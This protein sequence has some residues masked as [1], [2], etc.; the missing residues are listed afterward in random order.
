MED[1]E[2]F[3]QLDLLPKTAAAAFTPISIGDVEQFLH[4]AFRAM[5]PHPGPTIRG[6]L[7]FDLHLSENVVV[8]IFT[9]VHQGS[10]AGADVGTDAVRIGLYS[11]K[12]GRPLKAGKLPIVK[13][14]QNWRDNLRERIEDEIADYDDREGYWESRA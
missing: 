7:T 6:E 1:T 4:R 12:S 5:K 9:S 10:Q 8:R 13:R 3:T 11:A 2:L 14:T